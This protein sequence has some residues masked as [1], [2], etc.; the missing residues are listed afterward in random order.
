MPLTTFS[1]ERNGCLCNDCSTKGYGISVS[2]GALYT[3]RYIEE[4]RVNEL[5]NF[6]VSDNVL[7][8]VENVIKAYYKRWVDG[9]FKALKLLKITD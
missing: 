9:R 1:A 8:C 2:E 4:S 5:F 7:S 6:E 3:L